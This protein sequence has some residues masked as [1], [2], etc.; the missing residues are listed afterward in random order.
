MQ[1]K[2]S[3]FNSLAA[4]VVLAAFSIIL[5]LVPKGSVMAEIYYPGQTYTR[6]YFSYFWGPNPNDP[7]YNQYVQ[8]GAL[9]NRTFGNYN[10]TLKPA[11]PPVTKPV[12]YW[13]RPVTFYGVDPSPTHGAA[14][15]T[16][17]NYAPTGVYWY[18]LA[19]AGGPVYRS[20]GNY[21]NGR[22]VGQVYD[23]NGGRALVPH[24]LSN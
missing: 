24:D 21:G 2:S 22:P 17:G 9:K 13:D 19:S 15:L 23:T 20:G 14:A 8:S 16:P 1:N 12:L 11:T 6:N 4:L 7:A 18:G 10:D 3:K 5:F